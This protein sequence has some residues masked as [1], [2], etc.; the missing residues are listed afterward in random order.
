MEEMNTPANLRRFQDAEMNLDKN[1]LAEDP[2]TLA[3]ARI[4]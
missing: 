1:R 2:V 3:I 4:Q